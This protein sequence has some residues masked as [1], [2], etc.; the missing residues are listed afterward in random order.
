MWETLAAVHSF[1]QNKINYCIKKS[2]DAY[3]DLTKQYF[4]IR[5]RSDV[6]FFSLHTVVYVVA[7]FPIFSIKRD[8]LIRFSSSANDFNGQNMGPY[9]FIPLKFYLFCIYFFIRFFKFKMFHR[10]SFYCC[11]QQ[12]LSVVLGIFLLPGAEYALLI[13]FKTAAAILAVE[14]HLLAD[15]F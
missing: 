15:D 11:T 8:S 7:L 4:I 10:L 13:R 9:Y 3:R 2:L 5:D 12:K 14:K 6:C 1:L